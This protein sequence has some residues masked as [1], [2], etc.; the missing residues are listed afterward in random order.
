VLS[1]VSFKNK[2]TCFQCAGLTALSLEQRTSISKS[3]SVPRPYGYDKRGRE[4]LSLKVTLAEAIGFF[5]SRANR[6]HGWNA[7]NWTKCY[8]AYER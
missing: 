4:K 1:I 6:R 2:K 5:F 7:E 8:L 3:S